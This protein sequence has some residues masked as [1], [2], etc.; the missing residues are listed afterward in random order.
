MDGG[1]RGGTCYRRGKINLLWRKDWQGLEDAYQAK[2]R[3]G[4]RRRGSD[5]GVH[6]LGKKVNSV[7]GLAKWKWQG[8]LRA[9]RS[10]GMEKRDQ[11]KVIQQIRTRRSRFEPR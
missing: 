6:R 3:P 11:G 7:V 5:F 2:N 10:F 1:L 4:N 8:E 9:F